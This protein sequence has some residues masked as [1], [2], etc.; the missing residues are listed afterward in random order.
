MRGTAASCRRVDGGS[1]E[2][3][4]T[5]FGDTKWARPL[6]AQVAAGLAELHARGIVHRDLKPANILLDRGAAKIADFGLAAVRGSSSSHCDADALASTVTGVLRRGGLTRKD[7]LF[8][9][10]PY[11][12]PELAAG[13]A[14]VQ[15]SSDVFRSDSSRAS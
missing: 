7:D 8:G 2:R 10:P 6:L 1:L 11:M 3:Q 9:T 15:P 13:V 12:A 5:R 14:D 4:R